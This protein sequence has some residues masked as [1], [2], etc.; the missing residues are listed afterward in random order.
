MSVLARA[1]WDLAK[2]RL[3]LMVLVTTTL[4]YWLAGAPDGSLFRLLCLLVGTGLAGAGASA[5]NQYLE[6]DVDARMTRT[7]GRPL[8]VGSLDPLTVLMAGALAIL[9]GVLLLVEFVNLAAAFVVLLTAFLYV[10]VYTPL[11]KH[12]WWNT[13]VGAIPGALPP[14]AGWV[15]ATGDARAAGAWFL[16]ALLWAWQHPHFYAIAWLYRDDYAAGGLRMI[17]EGEGGG[18][19]MTRGVLA[20]LGVLLGVSFLPA[21][22]G[23]TGRAY[24]VAAALLG[25]LLAVAAVRLA[26][27]PSRETARAVFGAS[28]VYLPLLL[29][30]LAADRG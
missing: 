19:R 18:K 27:A 23:L 9:G 28:L 4:G 13:S 30:A 5:L 20:T 6:R 1:W 21:F 10:L 25:A 16:F 7:A 12:S 22:V 17:G 26:R 24:P 15:A 2:P 29:L 3:L 14:V 8:V 11:K